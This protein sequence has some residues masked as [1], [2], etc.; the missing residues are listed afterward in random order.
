MQKLLALL[1]NRTRS[2][3]SSFQARR[4]GAE[5]R[6]GGTRQ[7]VSITVCSQGRRNQFH[8]A[9]GARTCCCAPFEEQSG[10]FLSLLRTRSGQA[11]GRNDKEQLPPGWAL[12]P[13]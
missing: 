2:P 12:T 7:E 4:L 13:E 5:F 1:Q 6:G 9:P 11:A 3:R 8:A 10:V